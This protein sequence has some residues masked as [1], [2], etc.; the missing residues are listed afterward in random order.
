MLIKSIL[1]DGITPFLFELKILVVFKKYGMNKKSDRVIKSFY[2]I[3]SRTMI[4][5]VPY[6]IFYK[7][8]VFV[9][10]LIQVQSRWH[11][12]KEKYKPH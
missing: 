11:S 1:P 12:V 9:D 4:L 6:L 5:F 10:T 2:N 7:L 8:Y 3:C